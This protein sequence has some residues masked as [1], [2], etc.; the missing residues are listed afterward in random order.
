MP[1]FYL[2]V[3]FILNKNNNILDIKI[4]KYNLAGDFS[5]EKLLA[6]SI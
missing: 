2:I 4:C 5:Q 1:L 6:E 3:I